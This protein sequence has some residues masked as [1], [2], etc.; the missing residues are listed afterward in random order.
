MF[1]KYW[2]SSNSLPIDL[3]LLFHQVNTLYPN[4]YLFTTPLQA[5]DQVQDVRQVMLQTQLD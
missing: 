5:N 1:L 2:V 4:D 3:T